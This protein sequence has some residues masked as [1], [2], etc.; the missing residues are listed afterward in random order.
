MI[1]QRDVYRDQIRRARIEVIVEYLRQ[2]RRAR[3]NEIAK[4]LGQST[5][6][7]I[8]FLQR[9]EFNGIIQKMQSGYW[10]IDPWFW[11][12]GSEIHTVNT[13]SVEPR[14][15]SYVPKPDGTGLFW[16]S[17]SDV[18]L[19]QFIPFGS[20]CKQIPKIVKHP[21]IK[22]PRPVPGFWVRM[23]DYLRRWVWVRKG[24]V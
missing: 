10:E 17:K 23:R 5:S 4:L 16:W 8:K 6:G 14:G 12:H 3:S 24:G 9:L 18:M 22:R 13:L 11:D 21:V 15:I 19:P 20:Y 1:L 7:T 2:N